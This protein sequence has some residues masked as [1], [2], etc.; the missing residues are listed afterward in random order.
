MNKIPLI[1]ILSS[2]YNERHYIEKAIQ[3]VLNQTY[4]NWEWIIVD[5]QSTD[6]T[7]DIL[8]GIRDER[9]KYVYQG[10][11]GSLAKNMNKALAM[12]SGD[13]IATLDGDDYWPGNKLELQIKSFNDQ[14]VVLSYGECAIIDAGGRRIGYVGLPAEARVA[15]NDPRGSALRRL[16][17]DIDCFISNA[18]VMYRTSSLWGIGG[19]VERDSLY[20]D[21]STWIQ[22]S[23][24]GKFSPIPACLGYY[25]KHLKSMSF[26]ED[27]VSYLEKQVAFLRE[28]F[29]QNFQTLRASGLEIELDA[30]EAHWSRI[31]MKTH[32]INKL[33]QLSLLIGTDLVAPFVLLI[34]QNAYLRKMIRRILRL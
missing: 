9:V 33:R 10:R 18:T 17:V 32:A 25:R 8:R 6:G 13:I 1:S 22:L 20:P 23:L 14:D 11:T 4:E 19:F 7:G 2:V 26:T 31:K 27:Q 30:L 29:L 21:F 34:N 16:L 24:A 3:S 5:D 28:F 15:N 12:S